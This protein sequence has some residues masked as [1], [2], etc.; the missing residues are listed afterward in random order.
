MHFPRALLL[1]AA[2]SVRSYLWL[3][4][5]LRAGAWSRDT[6]IQGDCCSPTLIQCHATRGPA[7]NLARQLRQLHAQG[8]AEAA[9]RSQAPRQCG[10]QTSPEY[11]EG[12][13]CRPAPK[14]NTRPCEQ[15]ASCSSQ[16]MEC[17]WYRWGSMGDAG[18]THGDADAGLGS[19]PPHCHG[20]KA[21]GETDAQ[22][23]ACN[24]QQHGPL[25]WKPLF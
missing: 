6:L 19:G 13:G 5:R 9:A 4:L 22:P 21:C 23:K 25:C 15:S 7:A 3:K 2:C 18:G 17:R 24:H 10:Q 14:P 20:G 1:I 12:T 16:G 11:P 8:P